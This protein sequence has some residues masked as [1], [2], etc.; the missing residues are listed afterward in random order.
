MFVKKNNERIKL[1]FIIAI[2]LFLIIFF[3]IV[4]VQTVSYDKLSTLSD[5][6]W[7][8]ELPISASRGKILD[9]N[10]KV[11]ADNIT[12]T[13]LVIIP[14]QVKKPEKVWIHAF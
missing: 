5:D 4:Y 12:I 10:G 11:L 2:L 6:L 9:R 1:V 14:N 3:K 8:R 7:S 13:S